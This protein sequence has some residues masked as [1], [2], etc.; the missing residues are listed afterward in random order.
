MALNHHEIDTLYRSIGQEDAFCRNG[1]RV[2]RLF[3]Y[4]PKCKARKPFFYAE[5]ILHAPTKKSRPQ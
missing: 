1:H 4:C 5:E 2:F 3:S